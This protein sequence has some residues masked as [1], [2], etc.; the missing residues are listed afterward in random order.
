VGV[1]RGSAGGLFSAALSR[2][3]LLAMSAPTFSRDSDRE[4]LMETEAV[5]SEIHNCFT[6][7]RPPP[8][9][10]P[11]LRGRELRARRPSLGL[12][13]LTREGIFAVLPDSHKGEIFGD[14]V[15]VDREPILR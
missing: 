2:P 14:Y 5:L 9:P 7:Y 1:E 13:N 3:N 8:Q 11:N 15:A 12:V 4:A 10:S 6:A